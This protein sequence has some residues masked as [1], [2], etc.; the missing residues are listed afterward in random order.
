MAEEG[1]SASRAVSFLHLTQQLDGFV[2]VDLSSRL[3]V[4]SF[5]WIARQAEKIANPQSVGPEQIRLKRNAI[6]VA[7]SE[8]QHRFQAG[9][10]QQPADG[11]AAHPHHRSTAIGHIDG[12]DATTEL[13]CH[14]EGMAGISSSRWHHLRRDRGLPCF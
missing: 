5:D 4:S 10:E 1:S 8:L 11:K 7:T 12:M 2:L 6:A 13:G 9:I 14:G 3:L